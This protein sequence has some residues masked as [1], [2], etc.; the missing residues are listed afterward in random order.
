MWAFG[1]SP[2][3]KVTF[4]ALMALEQASGYLVRVVLADQV[5]QA[6]CLGFVQQ[7]EH[8]EV[9]AVE[10]HLVRLALAGVGLQEVLEVGVGHC[11]SSW[12]T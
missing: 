2:S 9:L 7:S 1:V 12:Q 11:H 5:V 8:L 6:S 10:G 4:E 3:P